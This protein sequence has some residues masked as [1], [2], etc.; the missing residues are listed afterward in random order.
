M[1]V[2]GKSALTATSRAWRAVILATIVSLATCAAIWWL[3]V[4]MEAVC[5]TVYPA[6]GGC[7]A[8]DRQSAGVTWT[9]VVAVGYVLTVAVALT[10][11]RRR[12]WATHA[13]MTTLV[14]I[15]V[16]SFGAVQGS[17]GFVVSY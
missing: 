15:A 2:D 8:A 3:A 10:V 14:V 1:T 7:T 17:T 11:G 4:P 5:P 9:I 6:P 12:Q 13:A 16:V